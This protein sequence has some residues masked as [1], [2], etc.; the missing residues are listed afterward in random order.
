[1]LL[2]DNNLLHFISFC[3]HNINAFSGTF[4]MCSIHQIIVDGFRSQAFDNLFGTDSRSLWRANVDSH[5]PSVAVTNL[6][7]VIE[8]VATAQSVHHVEATFLVVSVNNKA[9]G[10][11][12][13]R[14]AAIQNRQACRQLFVERAEP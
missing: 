7:K 13:F 14:H 2:S 5:R 10:T 11:I 6:I 12:F 1:M 4:R 8:S 3:A 9:V